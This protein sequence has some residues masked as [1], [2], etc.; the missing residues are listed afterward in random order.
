M[1]RRPLPPR[2]YFFNS[3]LVKGGKLLQIFRLEDLIAV[4]AAHIVD[5]VA[6]H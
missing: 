2:R 5:A 1:L 6:A 4:Q 3:L